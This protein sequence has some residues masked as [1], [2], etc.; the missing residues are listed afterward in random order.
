MSTRPISFS[1]CASPLWLP[2]AAAPWHG[3]RPIEL[4]EDDLAHVS[5]QGMVAFSNTTDGGLDF[6]T[7]TLNADV[8]LNANFKDLALGTYARDLGAGAI[9][10][11]D[12]NI[13]H[14]RFGR[15]DGTAAQNW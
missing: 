9:A 4:A 11:S 1:C 2:C 6:S 15:S 3:V 12:V 5:G 14:L 13:Q 7:I 8:T 10:G